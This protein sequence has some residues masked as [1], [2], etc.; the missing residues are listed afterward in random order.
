MN[1]ELPGLDQL[2]ELPLPAPVSYWPQTWGWAVLAL[3]LAVVAGGLALRGLRRWRRNR[4]RREAL[5][6]LGQIEAAAASDPLAARGLPA[7]LK[8]TALAA[9][10]PGGKAAPLTGEAWAAWLARNGPPL[11][12]DGAHLLATLAYGPDAAVRTLDPAEVRRLLA[13]ARHWMERHH[14]AA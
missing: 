11:P 3:L 14:V 4:Y 13:A 8:R 6:E 5:S 9:Q 2:R 10:A 7:L 1:A 12:G